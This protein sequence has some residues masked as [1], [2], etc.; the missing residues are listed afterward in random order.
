MKKLLLLGAL[1]LSFL[2]SSSFEQYPNA[3]TAMLGYMY[4]SEESNLEDGVIH[5]LR[6]NQNIYNGNS[7]F[8]V[9]SYQIALDIASFGYSNS[10]D[11]TGY[12]NLG[13]NFLWYFD[14]QSN[15]VPYMLLGAGVNYISRP[16]EPQHALSLYTN[17]GAGAELMIRSNVSLIGEAKYIY[18]GPKRSAVNTNIGLK[19]S[20]GD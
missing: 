10:N 8:A 14:T 7:P 6:F 5:G 4:N 16:K 13:G 15:F 20:Y 19:F 11:T 18:M 1:S 9:D 3:I 12:L 2:N 17:A